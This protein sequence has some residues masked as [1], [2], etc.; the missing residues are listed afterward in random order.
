VADV[1]S[2]A[3]PA[4]T[5]RSGTIVDATIISAPSSTKNAT[6]S[7]DPEMHQGKK[8][9]QWRFGMKVHVGASRQWLVQTVATGP[10]QRD[11]IT[12]LDGLLHGAEQ[13]LY[14]DQAYWCEDHRQ[15][16]KHA[17]IRYRVNCRPVSRQH[18]LTEHQRT[19]NRARSRRRARGEHACH[20]VKRLWGFAKVRYRGLAA[21]RLGRVDGGGC[22]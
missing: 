16:C 4:P 17:G 11:G 10:R 20:V 3:R 5:G 1:Q 19:I 21:Q 2:V 18:P 7:R 8:N 22:I 13:E 15:H 6:K 12:K 9:K 14:G